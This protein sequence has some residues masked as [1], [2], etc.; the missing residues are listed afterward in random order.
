MGGA[1]PATGQ[2]AAPT[3][4]EQGAP[5]AGGEQGGQ[6]P[7]AQAIQG[8]AQAVQANDCQSLMTACQ[9]LLGIISQSQGGGGEG[10]AQAPSQAEP[11]FAQRG[12]KITRT[13]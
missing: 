11:I 9:T 10:Q 6:D 2:P 13:R 1:A 3:G 7:L 12:Y 5:E 4:G 8:I